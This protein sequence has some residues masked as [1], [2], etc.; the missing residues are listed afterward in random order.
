MQ[1][2]VPGIDFGTLIELIENQSMADIKDIVLEA[3]EGVREVLLHSCCAPCSGAVLECLLNNGI[4]PTMFYYN[5]NIFPKEEY[6]KRK[7]EEIRYCASLGVKFIDGDYDHELWRGLV[8]GYEKCP[9]RSDRCLI[10]FKHRLTVAARETLD[11]GLKVFATT[12][13]TSRWKSLEQVSEAGRYAETQVPGS[14]FWD[15][16]WRKGGMSERRVAICKEQNFYLQQYCGCEM[17]LEG[18]LNRISEENRG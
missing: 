15:R 1:G 13:A 5:P 9:E 14:I 12:L 2:A 10:C 7:L 8:R 16:N 17:S 4:Q 11:L 3:P 6:E 18:S